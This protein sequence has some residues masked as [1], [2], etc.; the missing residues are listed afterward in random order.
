MQIDKNN[1]QAHLDCAKVLHQYLKGTNAGM[2][3]IDKAVKIKPTNPDIY[4]VRAYIK[5]DINDLPGSMADF[6]TAIKYS[7][8]EN[9][10]IA[11]IYSLRGELYYKQGFYEEAIQ[12]YNKMIEKR[13]NDAEL[14]KKRAKAL[15]EIE[16]YAAAAKD[17]SK[18]IKLKPDEI[19]NY[20]T[21]ANLYIEY[22]E[23][24]EL[25]IKVLDKAIEKLKDTTPEVYQ[26]K[27]E[28][29]LKMKKIPEAIAEF[30]NALDIDPKSEEAL[31]FKGNAELKLGEVDY[32]IEDYTKIIQNNPEYYKAYNKRAFCYIQKKNYQEAIKDYDRTLAL[33]SDLSSAYINR[34]KCKEILKDLQGALVD[35]STAISLNPKDLDIYVLRGNVKQALGDNTGALDDFNKAVK[36]ESF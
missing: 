32:A 29:L 24:K 6:N 13:P 27:G 4:M 36:D 2:T 22:L 16:H 5:A 11:D 17:Y 7:N 20:Y 15:K 25:G 33:N 34:A 19:D 28:V 30:N 9:K 3:L 21:L 18:I 14:Y 12:D 26:L 10:N 23:S 8:K 35:Y 31:Y 1:I